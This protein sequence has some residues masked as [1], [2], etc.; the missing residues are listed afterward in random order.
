MEAG[1]YRLKRRYETEEKKKG[2]SCDVRVGW[3]ESLEYS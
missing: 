2:G 3:V 1:F